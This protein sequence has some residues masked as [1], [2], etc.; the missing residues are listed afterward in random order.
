MLHH[1]V[2]HIRADGRWPENAGGGC[3]DRRNGRVMGQPLGQGLAREIA[4]GDNAGQR[5]MICH[6]KAG[7]P[8]LLQ[9]ARR[10]ADAGIRGAGDRLA[11]HQRLNPHMGQVA[12]AGR[13]LVRACRVAIKEFA[14]GLVIGTQLV[15]ERYRQADQLG[16]GIGAGGGDR[17]AIPQKPALAKGIA[18][19]QHRD[20]AAILILDRDLPV[21]NDVKA[22]HRR[23]KDIYIF[24][25]VQVN[26]LRL[27]RDIVAD[28]LGKQ[29]VRVL[30]RKEGQD[31]FGHDLRP[32]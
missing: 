11:H 23:A 30:M 16:L 25:G 31:I 15:K 27:D 5:A 22:A 7:N 3:H 20:D 14:E 6:A 17:L 12:G 19:L 28:V 32:V 1:Q 29:I 21:Q 10:H 9:Q 2:Q 18:A 4:D 24:I 26:L 8:A 13:V